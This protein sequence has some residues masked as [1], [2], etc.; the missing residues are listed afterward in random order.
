MIGWSPELR[1][2]TLSLVRPL[3]WARAVPGFRFE[4][5]SWGPGV[6]QMIAPGGAHL[7]VR[8]HGTPEVAFWLPDNLA[9]NHGW[10]FGLYLHPDR[11]YSERVRVAAKFPR[12]VGVGPAPARRRYRHAERQAAMLCIHDLAGTGASARDLAKTLFDPLPEDWR[13]SSERSDLR[14]LVEAGKRMILGNYREL[15]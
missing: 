6:Y 3:A 12:E 1:V 14:R 11:H 10:P 4:P 15:F 8:R 9:P 13:V 5:K 2:D 7:L